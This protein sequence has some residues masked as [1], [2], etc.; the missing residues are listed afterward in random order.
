MAALQP[1]R[2]LHKNSAR[3][4]TF[5]VR[6]CCGQVVQYTYT[7]K[8]DQRTVTAYKFEAWLIGKNPQD[9]CIGFV[10]DS[11]AECKNA[12]NK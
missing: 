3:V 8:K 4:A 1:L 11:E 2:A 12:K 7:S 10:K 6:P 9:Y 5:A